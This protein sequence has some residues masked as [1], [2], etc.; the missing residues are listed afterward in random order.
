MITTGIY[1]IYDKKARSLFSMLILCRH[2][3]QAIRA[4][5]DAMTQPDSPVAKHAEDFCLIQLA[6]MT[7]DNDDTIHPG[8]LPV[9][10]HP[11]TDKLEIVIQATTILESLIAA[12]ANRQDGPQLVR[13]D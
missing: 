7:E 6:E 2:V 9:W 1:A 13:K 3:A 12:Q 5:T 11:L 10:I 8:Q 4:M